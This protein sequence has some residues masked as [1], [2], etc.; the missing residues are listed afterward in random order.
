MRYI[1]ELED[2][3][4]IAPW[5]GDPGR[6]GAHLTRRAS[7]DRSQVRRSGKFVE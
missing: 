5:S 4:W 1:V 2:G 7:A 6:R 3:V